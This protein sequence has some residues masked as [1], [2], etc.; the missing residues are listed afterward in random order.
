MKYLAQLR[1]DMLFSAICASTVD[2]Q[3]VFFHYKRGRN[4][5]L[6]VCRTC[7]YVEDA[8]TDPTVKVMVMAVV[9]AL[10]P[11]R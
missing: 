9:A 2:H 1:A 4:Q 10:V 7:M 3:L 11:T 8:V 6:D 5:T